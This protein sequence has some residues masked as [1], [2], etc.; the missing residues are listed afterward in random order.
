MLLR[1]RAANQP[2]NPATEALRGMLDAYARGD[3]TTFNKQLADYRRILA[4]YEQSLVA[5]AEQLHEAGVRKAEILSQSKIDFEVF[6]NQFSPFYYAAVLYV[7]AFVLG[8]TSWLGWAVPLRRA[9]MWLRGL[10]VCDS[11][12]RARWPGSTSPAGRR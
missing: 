6:Y 1:D 4:D 3:A 10:H 7:V 5:N 2:V 11:H 9:S 12:L 8:A